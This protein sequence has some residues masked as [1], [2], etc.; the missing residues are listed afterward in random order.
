MTSHTS[1]TPTVVLF[2]E[3]VVHHTVAYHRLPRPKGLAGLSRLLFGVLV[4]WIAIALP[5]VPAQ[6]AMDQCPNAN[7]RALNGS[8]GLP[9]CRAYEMVTPPYKQGFEPKKP[10]Y[11]EGAVAYYSVGSFDGNAYGG[12]GNQYVARRSETGWNSIAM[13]PPGEQWVFLLS[14]EG[15]QSGFSSDF[16]SVL[17]LMRPRTEGPGERDTDHPER[18][19]VYVRRPD[20]VFSLVAPNPGT[21]NN[22][23]LASTPDLS[24]VVVGVDP[25]LGSHGGERV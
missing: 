12:L 2:K 22:R 16:R 19:G 24:H 1:T 23:V 5:V 25:G 3:S 11:G 6:A 14:P 13:N 15:S 8:S 17:W 20:G 10:T 18:D 4:A 7:L 9:D 21:A